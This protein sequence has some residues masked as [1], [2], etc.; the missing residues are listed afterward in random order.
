MFYL[1]FTICSIFEIIR[2]SI[3]T[4][5]NY[6]DAILEPEYQVPGVAL[7]QKETK[8]CRKVP[9]L[10]SRPRFVTRE[11]ILTRLVVPKGQPAFSTFFHKSEEM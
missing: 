5:F 10:F 11:S 3:Q 1:I 9:I 6:L 7:L 8:S 2:N 4:I